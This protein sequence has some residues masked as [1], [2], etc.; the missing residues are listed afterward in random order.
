M[1]R[2]NNNLYRGNLAESPV[3]VKMVHDETK[4]FFQNGV[5]NDIFV[6]QKN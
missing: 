6:L 3:N 1:N 4:I 5:W 2:D